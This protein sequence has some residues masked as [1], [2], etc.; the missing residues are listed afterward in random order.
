MHTKR[1]LLL[2]THFLAL[3]IVA[4]SSQR[5]EYL[6]KEPFTVSPGH[7][8]YIKFEVP[9]EGAH[10]VGKFRATGGSGNDIEVYIFDEDA[11]ENFKNGHEA[12]TYY[13]SRRVTVGKIDLR[14]KGGVYY[15]VFNNSFSIFSN[16]V[17]N[18]LISIGP[19][20]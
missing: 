8:V 18:G 10:I 2:L 14:L 13:N 19:N 1:S 17:V 11:F 15:L 7:Y 9:E 4:V 5:S 20:D 12:P 16:K 3:S 6:V